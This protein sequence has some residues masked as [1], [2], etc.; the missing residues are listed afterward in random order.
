MRQRVVKRVVR[1]GPPYVN[2]K[3]IFMA[4]AF[5]DISHPI[6]R[7]RHRA[8][9]RKCLNTLCDN[10]KVIY[11]TGEEFTGPLEFMQFWLDTVIEWR[12]ETGKKVLI[13]LSCTKDVQDAILADPVRG[14]CSG[15]TESPFP[16]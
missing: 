11:L 10:T 2:Q 7:Q 16:G 1:H 3:R 9:L 15:C 8:Y 4:E 5:Y 13:G 6:R 12:K 14:T